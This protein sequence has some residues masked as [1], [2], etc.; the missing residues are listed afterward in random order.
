[1]T[2]YWNIVSLVKL[3]FFNVIQCLKGFILISEKIQNTSYSLKKKT[4][5]ISP[6]YTFCLIER[7][8][9]SYIWSLKK[10]T[11]CNSWK[12]KYLLCEINVKQCFPSIYNSFLWM[13]YYIKEKWNPLKN[14]FLKRIFTYFIPFFQVSYHG[15]NKHVFLP[16][17]LPKV[18][19]CLWFRTCVMQFYYNFPK[20]KLK[21]FTIPCI[22]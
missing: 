10:Q 22:D 13:N 11:I 19:D 7:H 3:V 20:C 21:V 2:V 18:P 6:I 9:V 15:N 1:M 5:N 17:H 12:Q 8:I 16:N 14:T 4:R